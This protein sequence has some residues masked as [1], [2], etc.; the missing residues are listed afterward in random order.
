MTTIKGTPSEHDEAGIKIN[1]PVEEGTEAATTK[2]TGTRYLE[3]EKSY[4][5]TKDGFKY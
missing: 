3:C 5:S 1:Y 4:V 2:Q